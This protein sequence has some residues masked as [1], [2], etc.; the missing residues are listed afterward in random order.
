M[1]AIRLFA[2]IFAF[3]ENRV[4]EEQIRVVPRFRERSKEF[5]F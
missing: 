5:H 2:G 4:F 1:G 3:A